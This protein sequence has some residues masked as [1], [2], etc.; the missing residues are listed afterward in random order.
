MRKAIDFVKTPAVAIEKMAKSIEKII[1]QY[2]EDAQLKWAKTTNS[3]YLVGWGEINGKS[4]TYDIR[5]SDHA[6]PGYKAESYVDIYGEDDSDYQAEVYD[7]AGSQMVRDSIVKFF[8][9]L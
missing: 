6:K 1:R 5:F 8:Q 4:F 2:D 9:S 7:A 3:G